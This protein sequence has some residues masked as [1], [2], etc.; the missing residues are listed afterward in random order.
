MK[1][2]IIYSDDNLIVV[3]KP[4]GLSVH[5]G[6]QV[7][8]KTLVDFLLKEFPEI[9]SVG[10]DPLIRPGIVHRLD[11]D[12]SGVI[13]VARNQES[14]EYLK[15]LFKTRKIEKTYWAIVCGRP[16]EQ[17]G[18][19]SL[20]IGRLV[21]NP[22]KRGVDLFCS[23]P[24]VEHGAEHRLKRGIRAVREAVTEYRILKTY[25]TGLHKLK[26]ISSSARG[27]IFKN[28]VYSLLE[29]KPKT[30]RT[31]QIRVHLKALGHPVACDR[32]YGGKNVCC[33]SGAKRQLL[34][35]KSLSFSFPEGK[36]FC[37]EADPPPDFA[38]TIGG[39][40][41]EIVES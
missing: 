3:N 13:V 20:P 41:P 38:I 33:P 4:P 12:T 21:K 1:P 18:V 7:R 32:V 2:D 25:E 34:H 6:P 11:K 22:L 23:T 8:G 5:S 31:H 16:K 39:I 17:K 24:G 30:G 35:A 10:D 26:E 9:N 29:L 14:F 37:F 27:R 40:P 28:D 19:I 36:S 15:D